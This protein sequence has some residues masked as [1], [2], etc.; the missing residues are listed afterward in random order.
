MI[1]SSAL[2]GE[3]MTRLTRIAFITVAGMFLFASMKSTASELVG[4]YAIVDR[5]VL[6]PNEQSPERIQIWGTFSTS[7]DPA[8]AKRG[9]LYFRAP[10]PSEFRDAALKE[11]KDLKAVAGTGQAVAFGQHYFYIDQI[12]VADA[13]VKTLPRV[14]PASEKPDAPDG[15]P[16]NIGVSKLTNTTIVN[17]LKAAR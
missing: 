11:W 6:E 7:R 16:V 12:S 10:F 3:S 4:L 15:Y 8:A 2:P 13:Y 1:E 5:V 14:R 9:Y 17:Q